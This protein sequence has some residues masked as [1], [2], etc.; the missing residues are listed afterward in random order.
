[1]QGHHLAEL[2][3]GI[4]KHDW[5]DPRI[6]GFVD[7][8]DLVN[9]VAA[10]S[11][12]F[13]WR[14]DD[15]AMEHEQLDPDGPMGG[16]PRLASTLSV[17]ASLADLEHFVWHTVHKRF[18]DRRAEWYDLTDSLRFVMW[19]VPEGHRPGMAE[20]MARFRHM[21][22][23]GASDYAFGWDWARGQRG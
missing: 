13:V 14:L 18:Y 7:G 17:W 23:H 4:L 22:A 16:H 15:D 10:R 19:W 3:L 2:N 1:M 11:K 21:E 20:A 5:D 9:G 6:K 12:G 8:L